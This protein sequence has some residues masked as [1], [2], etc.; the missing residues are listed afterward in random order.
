[1]K[2]YFFDSSALVKR[3]VHEVGS[4]KVQAMTASTTSNIILASRITRVEVLSALARLQRE[5]KIDSS[6]MTMT[7]HLFHYDWMSQYQ[8]VELDQGII[9]LAGQ[10]VQRYP[11]RAYDSVQL[12][13]A[14]SLYPFLSR[15]DSQ[16]FTF[17][18]AD[19][20]LLTV[21]QTEGMPTENP[22]ER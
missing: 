17:V 7:I 22:N 6:K 9:E 13:S 8:I 15:I 18:S 12:A 19:D 4:I 16:I 10:L 2:L 14:L 1:M 5:G 3:Y 21:A 11:L 20:R